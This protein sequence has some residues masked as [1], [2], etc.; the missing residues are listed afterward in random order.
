[1]NILLSAG[2]PGDMGFLGKYGMLIYIV[3]I[4]AAMYFIVFRPQKKQKQKEQALRDNIQVGDEIITIG[5]FL[6]SALANSFVLIFIFL[7]GIP[8][9]EQM[10]VGFGNRFFL[11]FAAV[12]T[13]VSFDTFLK[14]SGLLGYN[15][16]IKRAI[17]GFLFARR[18]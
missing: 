13:G 4:I 16:V 11:C 6:F 10:V 17:G 12:G 9:S 8:I 15:A 2:Q 5:G 7:R 18:K 1:M 3:V 14:V